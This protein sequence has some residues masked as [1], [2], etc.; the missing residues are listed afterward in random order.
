MKVGRR[1]NRALRAGVPSLCALV[2]CASAW[3]QTRNFDIPAGDMKAALEA[4]AAQSGLQLV[5]KVEDLRGLTSP[6]LKRTAAADE[7]LTA[8]L[9]GSALAVRR[10]VS[11]AL[12]IFAAPTISPRG[13][14]GADSPSTIVVT[15]N[16]RREPAREV[17][18]QIGVMSADELSRSGANSLQDYLSREPGTNLNSWGGPGYGSIAIRGVTTGNDTSATVG[19]YVDDVAV[20]SSVPFL[21]GAIRALDLGLLDLRQVELLR[22]PQGT[23]Y[24]ASAMGGVLKYVTVDPDT[25]E[26]SGKVRLG[27]SSTSQGGSGSTV[28]GV[29]NIPLS[30]DVAGL[31]VSAFRDR[32]G[33]TVDTVGLVAA[34]DIEAGATTGLRASLLLTPRKDLRI[35]LTA[36]GQDIQRVGLDFV[37]Y[38]PASGQPVVGDLQRRLLLREPYNAKVEIL[39]AEIEADLGWARLNSITSS[40]SV[41]SNALGDLSLAYVPLLGS[42]GLT[43]ETAA[44]DVRIDGSKKT[45]ELRLTSRA[46]GTFDWLLG[47]Y[48]NDESG[49]NVQGVPTTMPGGSPGP[50]LATARVE[51]SYRERAIFG[52]ATW[53]LSERLS[54]NGGLR[55]ATNRQRS[56]VNTDGLLLGGPQNLADDSRDRTTTYL[57]TGRY[58][59]DAN[60]NLFVRTATAYR[61]GGPNPVLRDP[62]TGLPVAPNS[63]A[64]DTLSSVEAGYKGDLLEKRLSLSA[65]LFDIRWKNIQ[66]YTSV[67][68]VNVIV[69]AGQAH[70]QGLELSA[71]WRPARSWTWVFATALTD[72]RLSADAAGLQAK[73]GARLPNSARVAASLDLSHDFSLWGRPAYAGWTQRYVG[74]RNSGYEGSATAPNHRLPAYSLTD[75]RAGIALNRFGLEV[76][77]RNV[78]DER[79]QLAANSG[80]SA[81][82]GPVW[83]SHAQPRT[84]GAA[85]TVPF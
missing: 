82:G 27:V 9:R 80:A 18:M 19:V 58:L 4:Y 81:L 79:A 51:N 31:R 70:L 85:V 26:F 33:G 63:Y 6:G 2:L 3:A 46:G 44:A 73:D 42:F 5:Y 64:P 38:G 13:Q 59:L 7:A 40:Q 1:L 56:V 84:V 48:L 71:T 54:L 35:R 52:N 10:D 25:S 24:G 78:L 43:V 21:N 16:R 66:Q 55:V 37:D 50:S 8:L 72:A 39:A 32:A 62:T 36:T 57:L 15:A 11:G 14:L 49:T 29:V 28:S 69:S 65:A 68:G 41:R 67:N 60:S 12:V 34:R 75:L 83:V 76:Y 17:P 45:Q 22:G 47:L 20:G 53:R 61:P 30:Q 74:N 77:T 23:L